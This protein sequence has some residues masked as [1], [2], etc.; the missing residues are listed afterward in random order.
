MR[1]RDVVV[2]GMACFMIFASTASMAWAQ[3]VTFRLG[4]GGAAE[5]PMWLIMAKPDL[6]KNYGK[7]YVLDFHPVLQLR[8]TRTGVRSGRHR[9]FGGKRKRRHFCRRRGGNGKVHRVD[10]AR[11]RARL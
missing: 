7:A 11:K 8:Q 2:R 5:E 4:Y 10:L 9:S 3:P 1:G 6:A